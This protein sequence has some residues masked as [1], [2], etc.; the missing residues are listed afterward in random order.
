MLRR[1]RFSP[2]GTGATESA[3]MLPLRQGDAQWLY[4]YL[5]Q[6]DREGPLRI[7]LIQLLLSMSIPRHRRHRNDGKTSAANGFVGKWH[8]TYQHR[9]R[10][11]RQLSAQLEALNATERWSCSPYGNVTGDG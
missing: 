6:T 7:R 8:N 3:P 9:S 11:I 5:A 2:T 4:F 10:I 1:S